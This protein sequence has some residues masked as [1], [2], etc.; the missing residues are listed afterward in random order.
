MIKS[1]SI[2]NFQS[3]ENSTIEF[4]TGVNIIVGN[5]DS[6]KTAIIRA[7]R[8]IIWNRP[9]GDAIRSNWGNG[10]SVKLVTEEG[11]IFRSKDKHD[12]YIFTTNEKKSIEFKAFGTSVPEEINRFLNIN[13]I[14]VQSQLDAPFLLSET[15]GA[16]ASHFNK[17][18]KL[19]KIDTATQ[20]INSW[21]REL[22]SDIKYE[23]GQEKSL[24]EEVKKFEYL[25]KFEIDIEV[26]EE[27]EKQFRQLCNSKD[28]LETILNSYQINGETILEYQETIELEKPVNSILN[29][30]N[31]RAELD[32]KEV[33]LDKLVSQL[34]ELQTEIYEQNELIL[35]EKPVNS[36][37][38]LYNEKKEAELQHEKLFKAITQLNNIKMRLENTNEKYNT[39]K[40][41]FEEAMPAGSV[42]PLCNQIIKK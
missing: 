15:P 29:L 40:D 28:K 30:Y 23:E 31:E 34:K 9:S 25:E 18:A 10:T 27:Q 36:I 42:C 17:V 3:H 22:T 1:L 24:Q 19:D 21:I 14:N 16:V 35:L 11:N 12:T 20:N 8:W 6:G 4:S 41:E 2:Q 32:L 38:N 26:L 39:L 33:K 37:L 5:S 13:E 7:L